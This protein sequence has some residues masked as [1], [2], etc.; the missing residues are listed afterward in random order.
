MTFRRRRPRRTLS[1]IPLA[2]L[3]ILLI[4]PAT[5]LARV[6]FPPGYAGYHTYAEMSAATKAAADA[7]PTIARRFSIGQSYHGKQLWAMKISDNVA[8]DEAEPEV[9]YDGGHHADEH[10]GVEMMLRTMGW[11][12]NGYGSDSRITNI[13]N[14]REIW[15]VFNVNPDGSEADIVDRRFHFWRKNR[16]PTPGTGYIGTD[17]NRNYGY[18]WG[19]GGRTSSNPAAITYLGPSPFSAPETRAMRDFLRSRVVGGRQQIRAHITFHETG[20]LVMW[21]YGYTY[22]NLPIDMTSADY[23]A[24]V[25][26]GRAMAATNGYR[27]QQASD[28][29]ITRGTTRDYAYGV[30][31]IFSYTFEMSN[32]AYMD[33]SLIASETGRNKNAVL[34][35]AERAWCP[36]SVIGS[37]YT[38][39]RCGAFD[40]D[41]EAAR[42]WAVDPDGTD[43]ATN[44]K[45]ARANP[46]T[47]SSSGTKQLGTVASGARALS[48][49]PAAGA[50]ANSYDLDGRTSI[51]SVPIKMHSTTG[52]KLFFRY[53]FAHGSNSS[54][55]DRLVVSIE[56]SGGTRT[57]VFT[58][59]GSAA[60]VDGAWRNVT[61]PLETW[62][63]GT[64][65]I[66]IEA[67]D[68]GSNSLVE[69]QIEDVRVTRGT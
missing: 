47:T 30:Y 50:S 25:R 33:D 52:Q 31:R 55:A 66:H 39:S 56:D 12:L 8:T 46:A 35:L 58:R 37:S 61:V 36:Y 9:L 22:A 3:A 41:F 59:S 60:D 19:V 65:R 29:Y 10:M 45:W 23:L 49:G 21:P 14:S 42:G 26:M 48:T 57:P 43:T 16:Q 69:A 67:V 62:K 54:S 40:D 53:N 44:G 32:R 17:L 20:R 34:Y 18:N 24:F 64:I 4:A 2:A 11:L 5:A 1:I 15:I 13:V 7:N 38:T 27:P 6:E 68:G 63:G 28:L 51:R